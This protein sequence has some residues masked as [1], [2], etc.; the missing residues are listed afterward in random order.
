MLFQIEKLSFVKYVSSLFVGYESDDDVACTTDEDIMD[1]N[2]L[3]EDYPDT[4][5]HSK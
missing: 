1:R 4:W 2:D 5:C 3:S